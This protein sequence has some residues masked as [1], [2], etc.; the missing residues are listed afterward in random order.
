MIEKKNVKIEVLTTGKNECS[1]EC[2]FNSSGQYCILFEVSIGD[3]ENNNVR[4][5]K[6][7]NREIKDET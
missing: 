5:D 7:I 2:E 3:Q 4:C 6:C 1:V